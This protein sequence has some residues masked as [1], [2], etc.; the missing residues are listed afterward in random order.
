MYLIALKLFFSRLII[1]STNHKSGFSYLCFINFNPNLTIAV[2][3]LIYRT[4]KDNH[5]K[6]VV[7]KYRL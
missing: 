3:D 7:K 6:I 2:L 5:G 4:G 1:I